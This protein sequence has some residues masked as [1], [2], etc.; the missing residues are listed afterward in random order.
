MPPCVLLHGGFIGSESFLAEHD[1]ATRRSIIWGDH[2][3][4]D[5]GL[6]S[7]Q[8]NSRNVVRIVAG[9]DCTL[10]ERVTVTGGSADG[11]EAD[12]PL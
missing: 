7:H 8:E 10:L 11:A 5:D 2:A 12:A 4:D 6:S 9:D 1:L 3:G